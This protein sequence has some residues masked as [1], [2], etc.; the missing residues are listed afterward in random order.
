MAEKKKQDLALVIGLS[1]EKMAAIKEVLLSKGLEVEILKGHNEVLNEATSSS[2][3]II[4]CEVHQDPEAYDPVSLYGKLKRYAST[5]RAVFIA[6]ANKETISKATQ[7]F[8]TD[9]V[10]AYSNNVRLQADISQVVDTF[11]K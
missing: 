2:P 11:L 10:L 6:V 3:H 7:T 9:H 4:F 1:A 5:Q 8:G